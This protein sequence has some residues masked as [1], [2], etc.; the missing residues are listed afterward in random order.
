MR[1]GVL[2]DTHD[3]LDPRVLERFGGVEH[4]LHAGDVCHPVLIAELG[5]IAPVTVAAG[6]NDDFPGWPACAFV[7]LDGVRI[8]V[9]HIVRPGERDPA[10]HRALLRYRPGLVVFG[11]S[12]RP[13]LGTHDEVLYLNP[14]SAGSP[15]FR[16]PRSVAL[17][18]AHRGEVRAEILDLDG[19]AL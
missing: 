18:H 19:K 17:L 6:N 7:E 14:G 15:R 2:A 1:I 11:H 4:I 5:A 10:L 8:L 12:H 3:L 16:L 9:Q 13:Y